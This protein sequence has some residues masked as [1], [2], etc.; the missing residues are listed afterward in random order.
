[1]GAVDRERVRRSVDEVVRASR[2]LDA[3]IARLLD[4][5]TLEAGKLRLDLVEVDLTALAA[6]VARRPADAM[7]EHPPTAQVAEPVVVSG[8]PTRLE[9]VLTNLLDN[10]A[11]FSE[12]GQPIEVRVAAEG[13]EAVLSVR[14]RGRGVAPE[15]RGRVFERFRQGFD[16]RHH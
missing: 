6:D 15:L 2:R 5:T 10:A 14:D 13:G 7:G 16:D 3:L 4:V 11:K 8:D 12:P 1:D 9:Q